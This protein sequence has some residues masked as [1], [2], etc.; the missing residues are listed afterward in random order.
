MVTPILLVTP[1]HAPSQEIMRLAGDQ[2][3]TVELCASAEKAAGILSA[4]SKGI[5]AIFD[6]D[7]LDLDERYFRQLP[8]T[9]GHCLMGLSRS[10]FHPDLKEAIGRHLIA[11]LRKPIDTDELRFLLDS[12][13]KNG[14]AP[15]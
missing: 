8:K 13:A 9:P 6:L 3:F 7:R 1:D 14:C 15:E 5:I 10:P 4:S 2:A 11:C 12:F